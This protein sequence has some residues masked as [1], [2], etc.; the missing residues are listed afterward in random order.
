MRILLHPD[1][2]LREHCAP[3][4]VPD[5]AVRA[6][7]DEMLETMYAAPG[8]GLAGPQVGRLQRLFVMDAGW[9]EGAPTPEVCIDPEIT[10]ESPE[11]TVMEEGWLSLPD[12]PRRVSRPVQVRMVWTDAEGLRREHALD[13]ARARIAQ[14]EL[15][16]LN[17]VL[18]LDHPA[19]A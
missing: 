18:I 1:P 19:E 15:D 6:L 14:H 9:K 8:R 12:Q 4:G 2:L 5:A 10:W 17:G 16:H 7:A 3:V 13:G 11:T